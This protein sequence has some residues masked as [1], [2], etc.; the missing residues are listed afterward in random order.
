MPFIKKLKRIS[1]MYFFGHLAGHIADYFSKPKRATFEEKAHRYGITPNAAQREALERLQKGKDVVYASQE[2]QSDLQMKLQFAVYKA[3]GRIFKD[4]KKY[5]AE[6]IINNYYYDLTDFA[7]EKISKSIAYQQE[8]R[9][10]S[11]ALWDASLMERRKEYVKPMLSSISPSDP[12]LMKPANYQIKS[13][14]AP[15]DPSLIDEDLRQR[16]KE[17]CRRRFYRLPA[18]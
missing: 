12:S 18:A 10:S 3:E 1:G 8:K 15:W 16:R 6:N 11:L 9:I 17:I 4:S 2:E 5:H 7:Q 13:A 14:L